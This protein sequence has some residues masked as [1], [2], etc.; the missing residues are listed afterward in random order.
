MIKKIIL[1]ASLL[2]LPSIVLTTLELFY[3]NASVMTMQYSKYLSMLNIALGIGLMIFTLSRFKKYD[4]NGYAS[5]KTLFSYGEKVVLVWALIAATAISV[6][7]KTNEK[8]LNDIIDKSIKIQVD[9]INDKSGQISAKQK[10]TMDQM[11]A[12]QKNPISLFVINVVLI[13][14]MGTLYNLVA[15]GILKSRKP[16]V[17]ES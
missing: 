11:V 4:A 1:P 14:V 12:I 9:K 10:K 6:I 8:A 3:I 5:F 15:S 16:T 2:A 17:A 7:I 13:L